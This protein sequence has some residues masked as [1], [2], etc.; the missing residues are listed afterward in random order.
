MISLARAPITF[1]QAQMVS[2]KKFPRRSNRLVTR[3]AP[4]ASPADTGPDLQ[5]SR[6]LIGV[7]LTDSI[8]SPYFM[9]TSDHPGLILLSIKL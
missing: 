3:A 7:D 5:A 1:S 6:A 9:H 2:V 8:H 4:M